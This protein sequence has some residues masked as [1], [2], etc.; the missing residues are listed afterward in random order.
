MD[1]ISDNTSMPPTGRPAIFGEDLRV[2]INS[3]SRENYSNTPDYL[4][5]DFML[6]ALQ[7]LEDTIR[8]RDLWYGIK[9]SPAECGR[10]M[11]DGA[12]SGAR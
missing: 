2:A 3:H 1:T 9:P 7:A 12:E 6:Q 5:R 8:E 10:S 11:S 4:L